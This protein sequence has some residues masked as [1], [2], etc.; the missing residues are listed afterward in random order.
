MEKVR[1]FYRTANAILRI[2]G[3]SD[4]LT[5]LRLLEA[6]CV[7]VLTYGIEMIYVTDRNERRKLRVAYN[8]IFRKLFS[9]RMRDSV[10]QLQG[11]LGRPTWE[12]LL[13]S[14]RSNF[15][16]KAQVAPRGS[17]LRTIIA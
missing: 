9:Y 17:L 6:H 1:K 13:E 10:S 16:Q 3:R 2:D 4:E 15:I 11:F 7:P 12:E 8:S 5:M 14:R